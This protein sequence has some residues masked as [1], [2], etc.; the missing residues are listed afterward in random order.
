M[1]LN[2]LFSSPLGAQVAPIGSY[3]PKRSATA[4]A[5]ATGIGM[6]VGSLASAYANLK[7]QAD[8]NEANKE[9]NRENLA[10]QKE[11]WKQQQE[12]FKLQ[13]KWQL[14]DTA[15][16]RNWN[17]VASQ[18]AR[19]R[20]AG[21]NPALAMYGGAG[22]NQVQTG[23]VNPTAPSGSYPGQSMQMQPAQINLEGLGMSVGQAMQ[24]KMALERNESD[25]SVARQHVQ[26]ET[27]DTMSKM[28]QRGF[29]NEHFKRQAEQI[30]NQIKFDNEN[31]AERSRA[32][33]VANDKIKADQ[34]YQE[35]LTKAQKFA[36]EI[37]PEM[38]AL[39]KKRLAGDIAQAAA[40]VAELESRT[41]LNAKEK[42]L[43]G[44]HI[45]EQEVINK[46]LPKK[47]H[48]ENAILVKTYEH[49]KAQAAHV[50]QVT[51]TEKWHTLD[52]KKGYRQH[53]GSD[54]PLQD[55]VEDA[56]R[57]RNLK[58]LSK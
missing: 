17:S 7:N 42:E 23:T 6:G 46:N 40:A 21:L 4:A 14:E 27:L 25:M 1:K 48:N 11:Q 36:N 8:T 16:E 34:L 18:A 31:W 57:G 39:E 15:S 53:V 54:R 29:Q 45:V 22:Q 9:I 32:I 37:A 55:Y 35:E 58:S 2:Q 26:N 47:L 56:L 38:N 41:D 30:A 49:V 20:A 24:T 10:W 50:K 28:I 44:K 5:I 13:R 33:K 12:N 43:V 19:Y 51:E 3:R 52:A